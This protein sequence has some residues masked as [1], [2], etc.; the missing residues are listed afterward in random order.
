MSFDHLLIR[1]AEGE[2]RVDAADLPLRVGTGGDSNL[3]LPG[4]GGGPVVLLD[5]LDGQPFVQPVGGDTTLQINSEPL[6]TSRRLQQGDELEF[7]GS[8]I[9]VIVRDNTLVLEVHLEDSAYVTQPPL[10]ESAE[11]LA[12]QEQIAPTAF[13][14]A[15]ETQAQIEESRQSPLKIVIGVALVFLLTASFLLFT[16][17]SI[18]FDIEP[19]DPDSV[20][21]AGGWFRFPIGDRILLRQGE[22]TVHVTKQGYYDI[23]QAFTVGEEPSMRLN[24]EMRRL[25]GQLTVTT[26]PLVEAFVSVDGAIVGKVPHGPIELQPGEHSVEIDADRY[27][28]YTGVVDIPGLGREETLAV[29]L[30]PRWADVSVTSEPA[31]ATIFSGKERVGE[32]PAVLQLLEGKH[33]ISVVREGYAAWDGTVA[34]ESNVAQALPLIE[35]QPANAKLQV[36]TIPRAANVTVNGRYRGQSP[37]TLDLSPDVDYVIG[38]SKVGYGSARRQVRLDAAVS[39]ALTVDLSARTGRVT[40]NVTP[41]DATIYIDGRPRG[42][43]SRSFDL[44]SAPHRIEVKKEG[45]ESWSRSITPRPGYPQSLSARIRTL[46]E[47]ERAKIQMTQTTSQEQ[48]MRRVEPGSFT[49]GS[50]RSDPG[51][52]ANEVLVPVTI[53]KPFL[54]SVRE[55]SNREFRQ[56]RENHDSGSDI[57]AAMAGDDNPVAMVSWGDA[58]E[59]CNWL[60]AIEGLT[61]A[62]EQKFGEWIAIRPVT[63]GYRLPTEAEWAWAIR[64]SGSAGAQRFPWGDAMPPKKESGNYADQSA[65]DLVPTV[66]PRY[67]DGFASTSATGR[68]P[69]NS[70]G[71]FDGGGNVAEWV[72]DFYTVPTPGL[73]NPVIDPLGPENG[74]PRVIRG[75]SWRHAGETELRWTYR[76]YGTEARP[77]VGFRIV[78]SLD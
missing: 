56:F 12:A 26:E 16:S 17:K 44:S 70:I 40:V 18:R 48:V 38:L 75:S 11:T 20:K 47:I 54:I 57:H 72:N 68:F 59:Y 60:S 2:R 69:P 55:I 45:Y 22:H 33:Q 10:Q 32:T 61:P 3:R 76:D 24:I 7:F 67:D 49:M 39:E 46:E 58:A 43:G 5:L 14:R 27:L 63:N 73:R 78:R 37:L 6:R 52:R 30:V 15:S 42:S 1:D 28:P 41:A 51:R 34:A 8:R 29:Q 36:N 71:I 23:R 64:F 53:T 74:K 66:I 35:L 25:P 13:R 65:R 9:V 19:V 77:D 31:G 21:I 4:P 50:S 62:Y